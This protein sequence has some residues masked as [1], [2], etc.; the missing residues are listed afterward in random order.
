MKCLKHTCN[1][2]T[3][4]FEE[5]RPGVQ[6]PIGTIQ[7][8]CAPQ[9]RERIRKEEK[10][11]REEEKRWK[12]ERGRK[13]RKK[14]KMACKSV[15]SPGNLQLISLVFFLFFSSSFP[16]LKWHW[17][18]NLGG[19]H[20]NE[21]RFIRIRRN[22]QCATGNTSMQQILQQEILHVAISCVRVKKSLCF[23]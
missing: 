18:L 11:K 21:V 17:A 23:L 16:F 10:N 3:K 7:L 8:V 14:A 6:G 12:G 2:S 20:F 15:L 13:R 19:Y 5:G 1:S 22:S 9:K 4:Q